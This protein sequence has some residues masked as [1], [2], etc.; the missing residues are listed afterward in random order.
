MIPPP[1]S[2]SLPG[3]AQ[4]A[5]T[6][7]RPVATLRESLKAA[8]RDVPDFP[9]PGI[10]F[11]D[12]TPLLADAALF[13]QTTSAL[14]APFRR[15]GV[16]H[17][18]AVEARGFIVGAPVA[19]HLAAGFIPVRKGG[20]LPWRTERVEYALEYGSGMLEIH[21]DVSDH[22]MRVLVVDDVL[23]TGG[24][25]AATCTLVERLGGTVVGCSFLIELGF[26]HGRRAMGDR[27]IETLLAY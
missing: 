10:I 6:D 3:S 4:V 16:T 17:V 22:P 20:K 19:Q 13:Q 15:D 24:T 9:S 27:R 26:L 23:A 2:Q 1:S 14:A 18:V 12:I 5:A 8:V 25:A 11:K 21:R 7:S